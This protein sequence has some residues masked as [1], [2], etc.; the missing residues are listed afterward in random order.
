MSGSAAEKAAKAAKVEQS[1][2]SIL[3]SNDLCEVLDLSHKKIAE[4]KK[5]RRQCVLALHDPVGSAGDPA[6]KEGS[7]SWF[8]SL[9]ECLLSRDQLRV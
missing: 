9:W 1:R 4:M 6:L 7:A 8:V 5:N 2:E 3:R